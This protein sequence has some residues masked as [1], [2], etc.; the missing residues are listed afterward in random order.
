MGKDKNS[1]IMYADV[2]EYT[3]DLSDEQMGK[4]YRAQLRYANGQD[5]AIDDPEVKGV[6]RVIKHF[7]DTDSKKYADKCEQMRANASKRKQKQADA[8]NREQIETD[9]DN[10][11]VNDNDSKERVSKDTPK[12]VRTHFTPPTREEV[13]EYCRERNNHV[14]AD[15]FVD[16]YTAKG[17]AV[18]KNPMKDWKAAVRTWEQ[19]E[20]GE[21]GYT[22]LRYYLTDDS[23]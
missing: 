5:P 6:F 17:W 4:L 22:G 14:N 21:S 23:S 19:R 3:Q 15:Q 2:I 7:M 20:K 11:N 1:F 18:G 9:N 16:F 10:D 12:K 8:G 13:S